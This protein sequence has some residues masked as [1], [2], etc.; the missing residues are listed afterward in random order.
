MDNQ[1]LKNHALSAQEK[2]Y[3][4]Y[5]R[6]KVGA[7]ILGNDGNVYS[8]CNVENVAYPLGQCAEATA[9]GSM[10]NNAC[11]KIDKIVIVSP[12]DMLCF[13]CGGCRQKIAEFADKN[14]EI[15]MF[16]QQGKEKSV[17]LD[18]LL[19]FAFNMD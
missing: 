19:P 5:S 3:A 13:P 9:I 7:A 2:A 18:E 10:V 11:T 16:S 12:N 17:L 6:F 14:T 15:V 4:P 1:T 8:G